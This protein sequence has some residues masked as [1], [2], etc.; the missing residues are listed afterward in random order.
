MFF[1]DPPGRSDSDSLF[2]HGE[3]VWENNYIF[4]HDQEPIHLEIH[5][6][7]F[8]DVVRR[9]EDLNHTKGPLHSAV[10]TSER[11]SAM[12]QQV[13]SHY[14]WKS[15]YYFFHG[16]ASLDWYRGYDR[17]FLIKP[18]DQR[19]ITHSF[20]SPNRIVGGLRHHR[21]LIMYHLLQ[22]QVSNALISFPMVCP[23]ENIA[24]VDLVKEF[25]AQYPDIVNT[26]TAA[27]LPWNFDGELDHPMHSCWL[28]LF[29]ECNSTA[30]Y[31]VTETVFFGQRH[32]LTEKTFK[33]ICLK[34]PFVLASTA[35]SLEYLRSYGFKTFGDVWDESYDLET[36]DHARI[37]KI[38][39]L[40]QYLDSL[41]ATEL[42]NTYKAC[43]PAVQHNHEHFYSGAFEK[44]L[45]A[46]LSHMLEDMTRDFRI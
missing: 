18:P 31:M 8:D 12:V 22:Q 46:E 36:D 4:F 32:H 16:W 42:Q 21:L 25:S 29:D 41:D 20:I 11:D 30:A 44:L 6:E 17:T 26:F 9:N 14:G 1:C 43:L 15:Y 33:P 19:K 37:K 27:G 2:N 45:W 5:T 24:V 38:S 10:I 13:C 7:L 39:D 34:M 40:L 28:S 35:G 23:H 3:D